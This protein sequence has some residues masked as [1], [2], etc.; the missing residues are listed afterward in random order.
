MRFIATRDLEEFAANV[1]GFLAA[2]LDRHVLATVLWHA[3]RGRFDADPPLC[4]YCLD[5][6]ERVCAAA[7]RTPPAPLLAS[8]LDD[9]L[10]ATLIER[11]LPEDPDVPGVVALSSTARAIAAAWEHATGRQSR[12]RM[13][14]AMYELRA[15]SDPP[16]PAPGELRLATAANRELLIEWEQLFVVEAGVVVV[17]DAQQL[18]DRRLRN[19]SQYLWHADGPVSTLVLSP[20]I[21]DTVRIGPVYTP[22]PHRRRGYAGS[23]VA[24]A[25]RLAL[26]GGAERCA[27]FADLD[28]PTSNRVYL[29]VGFSAIADWEEHAFGLPQDPPESGRLSAARSR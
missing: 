10:A 7:L 14:E 19:R 4:A 22:P 11:W 3:R 16:V 20:M 5:A 23:A 25:C 29:S 24:A 9:A 21:A 28:N 6:E 8:E 27:L 2:R 12:C 15:V 17:G 26:A 18:V 13:R 1:E